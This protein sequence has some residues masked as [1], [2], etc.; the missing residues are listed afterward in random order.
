MHRGRCVPKSCGDLRTRNVVANFVKVAGDLCLHCAEDLQRNEASEARLT[1][2]A[3][4]SL[5]WSKPM[6]NTESMFELIVS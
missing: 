1:E 2:Q 3:V 5:E 6:E 4:R